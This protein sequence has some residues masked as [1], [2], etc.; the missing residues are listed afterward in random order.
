MCVKVCVCVFV[1]KEEKNKSL[2]AAAITKIT[3]QKASMDQLRKIGVG[4]GGMSSL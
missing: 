4:V 2:S 3:K 1:C